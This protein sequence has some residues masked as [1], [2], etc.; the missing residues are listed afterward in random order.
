MTEEIS[1]AF[2]KPV[3]QTSLDS[4]VKKSDFSRQKIIFIFIVNFFPVGYKP[5]EPNIAQQTMYYSLWEMKDKEKQGAEEV[6]DFCCFSF[7]VDKFLSLITSKAIN[8]HLAHVAKAT[9]NFKSHGRNTEV[10]S[11]VCHLEKSQEICL[12]DMFTIKVTVLSIL[13]TSYIIIV[14][15]AFHAFWPVKEKVISSTIHLWVANDKNSS[16]Q[17]E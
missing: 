14:N 4:I 17:L 3:L 10:T 6:R 2:Q 15:S 1:D 13:Y 12:N 9:S 8:F 5:E 11:L 16:Q 7:M